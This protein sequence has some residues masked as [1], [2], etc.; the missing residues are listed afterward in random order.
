MAKAKKPTDGHIKTQL[1][2]RLTEEAFA[3][4][5]RLRARDGTTTA[6]TV[7]RAL[8]A[9]EQVNEGEPLSA[10]L[11]RAAAK[12]DQLEARAADADSLKREAAAKAAARFAKKPQEG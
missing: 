1:N 11:R 2:V 6:D 10:A 7:A 8:A 3:R 9:F 12:L 5:E 4:L